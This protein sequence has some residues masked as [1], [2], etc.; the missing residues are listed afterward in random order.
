MTDPYLLIM[1]DISED[2]YDGLVL[3]GYYNVAKKKE[4]CSLEAKLFH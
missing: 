3:E 4:K 1:I 2:L